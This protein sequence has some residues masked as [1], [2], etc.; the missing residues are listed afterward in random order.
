MDITSNSQDKLTKK[1]VVIS[2]ENLISFQILGMK[3]LTGFNSVSLCLYFS[4]DVT[5]ELRLEY[6]A[7]AIMSAK[8]CN[9]RT[10][11]S[12]EGEFLHELEEKLEVARIQM[13]VYQ[14]LVRINAANP[15]RRIDEA[16]MRLNSQ[17]LDVTTVRILSMLSLHFLLSSG[18]R[19]LSKESNEK[20]K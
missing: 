9:L 19:F 11:G 4:A 13:Q 8:S 12:G 10:D 3:G 2:W 7:R 1:C 20:E 18:R 6:L 16:L 15:S 5:L 14:A 17:L